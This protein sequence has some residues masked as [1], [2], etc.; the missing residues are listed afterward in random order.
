MNAR[1]FQR[2]VF[3]LLLCCLSQVTAAETVDINDA[4]AITNA[5]C[6]YDLSGLSPTLIAASVEPFSPS[7]IKVI[8]R[9][10]LKS[11]T[12]RI[13]A[14]LSISCADPLNN[15]TS[16]GESVPDA[17]SVIQ[18]EDAGGRYFRHV[19]S[20]KLVQGRN[21]RANVAV[22]DYALGDAQ[23]VRK[24]EL[25][26]CN[27]DAVSPCISLSVIKPQRLSGKDLK[28]AYSMIERI[29]VIRKDGSSVVDQKNAPSI[30][31]PASR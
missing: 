18:D 31:A 5:R 26:A 17:K 3:S 15:F 21:W 30:A 7:G 10:K 14:Q 11:Q 13:S 25:V 1:S 22:V 8:F 23:Q 19:A 6:G 28:L 9:L 16:D 24:N 2:L 4:L 20:Q 12:Q 29:A 27:A